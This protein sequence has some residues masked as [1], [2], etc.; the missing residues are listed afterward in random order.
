MV[1][2]KFSL[3]SQ[4]EPG[5]VFIELIFNACY[6]FKGTHAVAWAYF[7]NQQIIMICKSYI[8]H[9]C[10]SFCG[11]IWIKNKNRVVHWSNMGITFSCVYFY[12]FFNL[13]F[14]LCIWAHPTLTV[15]FFL[16]IFISFKANLCFNK[17]LFYNRKLFIVLMTFFTWLL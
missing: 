15:I 9:V 3:K 6:A 14:F 13:F 1:K 7:V 4:T 10:Y 8:F 16:W 11:Y 5:T 12:T 17:L 2:Y